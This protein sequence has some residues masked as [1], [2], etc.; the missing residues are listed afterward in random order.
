VERRGPKAAQSIRRKDAQDTTLDH[1]GVLPFCRCAFRV[2]AIDTETR[3]L[4]SEFNDDLA[5][6]SYAGWDER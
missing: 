3:A 2:G 4:G 1:D 5:A 6:V